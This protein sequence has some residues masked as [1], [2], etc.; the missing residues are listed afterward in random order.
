MV[1]GEIGGRVGDRRRGRPACR[2]ADSRDKRFAASTTW[3]CPTPARKGRVPGA[4]GS[5][6]R[7]RATAKKKPLESA[8]CLG[9]RLYLHLDA[10]VPQ[11]LEE[12]LREP[13]FVAVHKV[14]VAKVMEFDA[15]AE[16]VVDI[17]E[18]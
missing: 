12:P 8:G 17:G 3:G 18:H 13:G 10:E 9:G 2:A 5:A 4:P 15:V 16:Q 7:T 14:L 11:A 1:R 6:G